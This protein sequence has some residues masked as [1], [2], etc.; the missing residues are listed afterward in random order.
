MIILNN[1]KVIEVIFRIGIAAT[2]FGHGYYALNGRQ[3]WIPLLCAYGFDIE[4]AQLL[5]PIIGLMDIIV[6][7][8]VLLKPIRIILLWAAIWAFATAMSRPLSGMD[9]LEM[10]E[11]SANWALPLTYLLYQGFP[12]S[13]QEFFSY[14]PLSRF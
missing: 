14:Q 5:L 13:W 2:F 6:A 4:T 9:V 10:I 1:L 8:I 7:L 12:K 11:R 3:D